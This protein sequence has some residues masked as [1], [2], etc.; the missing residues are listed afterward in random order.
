MPP[1]GAI[2]IR[3]VRHAPADAGGR[4]AGRRDIGLLPIDPAA[5]APLRAALAGVERVAA[6]PARRCLETA[7]ALFPGRAVATDPRLLEQ[8]FGA[9]EGLPLAALPDLGPLPREALAERRPPG[10]ESF[11]EMVRR[12]APALAELAEGGP[13]PVAVIAHA[14]TVRAALAAALGVVAPALA[15]EVAPLS[16]TRLR[17][18]GGAWSIAAVNVTPA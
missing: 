16:V 5:L 6:S 14:G 10:G 1:S 4:L 9:E 18:A 11:A 3:L 12:V 17:W 13:G 15:F 2:E 7:G 8:D